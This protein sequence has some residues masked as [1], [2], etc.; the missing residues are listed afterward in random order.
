MWFKFW[1]TVSWSTA[2]CN[3]CALATVMSENV[4]KMAVRNIYYFKFLFDHSE[5]LTKFF[6][7]VHKFVV[8]LKYNTIQTT[9]KEKQPVA[10]LGTWIEI[11]STKCSTFWVEFHQK[12]MI[13]KKSL[14]WRIK[15]QTRMYSS[16]AHYGK[17]IKIKKTQ[18]GMAASE[19]VGVGGV[20]W[21][22]ICKHTKDN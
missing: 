22:P 20:K 15:G 12:T 21:M 7:Q 16:P 9:A 6:K 4:S 19:C 13:K 2:G 14:K 1:A 17:K 11:I 18:P 3:R 5:R 10:F 8:V